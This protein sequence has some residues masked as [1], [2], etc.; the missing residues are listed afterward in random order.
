ME[1]NIL[2]RR[3]GLKFAD[4]LYVWLVKFSDQRST[5]LFMHLIN[6]HT[7]NLLLT[8]SYSEKTSL[9]ILPERKN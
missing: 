2:L 3:I 7:Q 6:M 1:K 5:K 8:M 9:N 4:L